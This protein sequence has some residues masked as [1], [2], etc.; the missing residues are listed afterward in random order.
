LSDAVKQLEDLGATHVFTYDDL[1][2]KAFTK[3]IKEITG[4]KVRGIQSIL[5]RRILTIAKNIKLGLNCVGGKET[6]LMSRLLG[7]GANL[8]SYGA[9]SKQPLSL[10]T[11]LF[12]FKDLVSRGFWQSRWYEQHSR[13]EKE[14][15]Y[16]NLVKLDV[17][18]T[19][20][21]YWLFLIRCV[22][23]AQGTRA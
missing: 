1:G 13:Q 7:T 11:S 8:V 18:L 15:L 20:H 4:G 6:T 10:P 21:F 17:C 2:D 22:L 23:L 16:Q 19:A 12:I 14:A 3:K 5:S 9:M